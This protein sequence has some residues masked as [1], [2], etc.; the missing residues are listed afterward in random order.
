[1]E[2]AKNNLRCLVRAVLVDYRAEARLKRI[3]AGIESEDEEKIYCKKEQRNVQW[4][5][6]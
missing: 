6:G 1:M 4:L 5:G 2:V 3:V